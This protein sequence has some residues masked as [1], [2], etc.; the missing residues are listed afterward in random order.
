MP[1]GSLMQYSASC[2]NLIV[3]RINFSSQIS[4]LWNEV[5]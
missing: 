2:A 4:I 5:N 3:T 1:I